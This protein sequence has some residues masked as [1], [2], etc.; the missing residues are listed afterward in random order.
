ML[1]A[2]EERAKAL[3]A[4]NDPPI[5]THEQFVELVESVPDNDIHDPEELLLGK[6]RCALDTHIISLA[7]CVFSGGL[8]PLKSVQLADQTDA[9]VFTTDSESK[10]ASLV[11]F[12]VCSPLD[13]LV[14][15]AG[16]D[17]SPLLTLQ[18]SPCLFGGFLVCSFSLNIRTAL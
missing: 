3:R 7:V 15:F 6:A 17:A 16:H 12:G 10:Q 5:L 18:V 13:C 8:K 4:S 1:G 9:W 14:S 2:V 11:V